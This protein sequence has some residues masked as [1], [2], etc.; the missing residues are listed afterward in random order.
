M[1]A[2][3]SLRAAPHL[4]RA[5]GNGALR[6]AAVRRGAAAMR[7]VPRAG[8]SVPRAA[9]GVEPPRSSSVK[10]RAGAIWWKSVSQRPRA[11]LG[12]GISQGRWQRLIGAAFLFLY[13]KGLS[14]LDNKRMAKGFLIIGMHMGS[15]AMP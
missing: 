6:A 7:S 11:P 15:K 12:G 4:H 13:G 1:P 10:R 9:D 14:S 8:R 2:L 5:S 3:W